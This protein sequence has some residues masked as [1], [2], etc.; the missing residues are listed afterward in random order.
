MN[1]VHRGPALDPDE[2][3]A[4]A[5][6][7]IAHLSRP[8]PRGPEPPDRERRRGAARAGA[9][10]GARRHQ[11]R[12][13]KDHDQARDEPLPGLCGQERLSHASLYDG[14]SRPRAGR[15]RH[16]EAVT[17]WI[18]ESN[19]MWSAKLRQSMR[20]L[21][22]EAQVLKTIPEEGA[23]D[24]AIVNLGEGDPAALIAALRAR[25]VPTIA[26][27]G[28]KEQALHQVGREAGA[29]V[30]VTNSELANKPAEVL[31]RLA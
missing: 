2:I 27:A 11:E 1:E 17:L 14:A 28:H 26:H 31:G 18:F 16:N 3:P 15:S 13:E 22:H 20:M 9:G 30:L 8:S 24:A 21:G 6:A 7:P 23:A 4:E 19:L 12:T 10:V 5:P 25:G 29:T